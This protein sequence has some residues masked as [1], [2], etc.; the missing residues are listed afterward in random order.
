MNQDFIEVY[1]DLIT[2]DTCNTIIDGIDNILDNRV[3][4]Y[5]QKHTVADRRVD[6]AIFAEHDY[7]EAHKIINDALG[8]AIELYIEKYSIID[9]RDTKVVMP[10]STWSVKL[11]KTPIGGGF[12]QWHCENSGNKDTERILAW[13]VYLN[14]FK[15]EAETEF[16]QHGKR[17]NPV[18]GAVSIWPAYWTHMHRGN[19]PYS[20]DKYI[21][22]GWFSFNGEQ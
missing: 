6:S 19:P 7:Q 4:P 21:A 9:H 11:Q 14:T 2:E 16:L 5:M 1:P 15:G 3:T 13:T 8:R 20:K 17:I 10:F 18:A 12:H 22:T